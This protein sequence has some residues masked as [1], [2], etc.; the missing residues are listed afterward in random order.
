[1]LAG[2][3]DPLLVVDRD[4]HSAESVDELRRTLRQWGVVGWVWERK[5]LESYLLCPAAIARASGASA[6]EVSEVLAGITMPMYEEVLFQSVASWKQDFPDDRRL[7]DA[8]LAKRFVDRLRTAWEDPLER[9]WRCPAKE[10][11]SAL[12]RELEE[13][14]ARSVSVDGIVRKMEASDVPSELS[15]LIRLVERKL[16]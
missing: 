12:N 5:E 3:V 9:L 8:T 13:R 14:G 15:E 16:R 11:L 7:A 4:Y 1:L 6:E 2:S 10:C